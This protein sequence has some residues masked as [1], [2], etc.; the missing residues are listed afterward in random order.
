MKIHI[1]ESQLPSILLKEFK[2]LNLKDS[3]P[4]SKSKEK[5]EK[6]INNSKISGLL[7]LE[8]SLIE[9]EVLLFAPLLIRLRID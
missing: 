6:S 4:N 3:L 5:K 2:T 7:N 9:E 8:S 1:K